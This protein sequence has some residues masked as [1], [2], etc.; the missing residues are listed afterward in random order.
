LPK[1]SPARGSFPRN[2]PV[3][4]GPGNVLTKE[5]QHDLP[6]A[7]WSLGTFRDQRA[8]PFVRISGRHADD[9]PSLGP[10]ARARAYHVPR[11]RS[12]ERDEDDPQTRCAARI[13][14]SDGSCPPAS[15]ATPVAKTGSPSSPIT[16][17]PAP[18]KITDACDGDGRSRARASSG[19]SSTNHPE[20]LLP[21]AVTSLPPS[22]KTVNEDPDQNTTPRSSGN[23]SASRPIPSLDRLGLHRHG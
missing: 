21:H 9:R 13:P 11:T 18:R 17:E 5:C 10:S 2:E 6:G 3:D 7:P 23:L 16:P 20:G 14:I 4:H 15:D 12:R 22:A 1:P 8:R 19:T